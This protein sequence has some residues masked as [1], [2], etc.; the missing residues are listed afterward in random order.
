M[1][2]KDLLVEIGTEELPPRSLAK[3]ARAFAQSVFVGLADAGLKGGGHEHYAT[4]RRLAVLINDLPVRQ[5]DQVIERKGP[6]MV[7]AFGDNGEP[8][9]AALGFA[10]SCGVEVEDLIKV[11]TDKGA[12]LGFRSEQKGESAAHLLPD[13]VNQALMNL[14][15]AKRMR[16]GANEV[17]FVRPVHWVV[18][19]LGDKPVKAKVL[20]VDT[21]RETRG[22]RFHHPQALE[23]N[24]PR[25]YLA[26]LN[27]Q[28]KVIPELDARREVIRA[29]VDKA[30]TTLGGH[31]VIDPDLL[32]QVTALV[33]WPCALAAHFDQR[34]LEVPPEVL[35]STMQD[36]QRYF[37][38]VNDD[39][40]LQPHFITVANIES[41]D[42]DKVREGNERVIRPRFEDAAFFWTQDR[43]GRLADHIDAL[44]GVVFQ[45][46]LG[47]VFDKSERVSALATF[48]A[49]RLGVDQSL[50]R[51]AAVLSKCDLMTQM[52]GEFPALQGVMGR[53]YATHDGEPAAVAAAM[54]E[55]YLPRHA[56]DELPAGD[57]AQVLALADRLDT[58]VGIYAI[59]H[60]PTGARDPFGLRR[61]ALGVIRIAIE[62]KLDLDLEELLRGAAENFPTAVTADA[63]VPEVLAYIMDRLD[64]Y[65]AERDIGGDAVVAVLARKPT[66]LLDI[67]HRVRAVTHFRTLPDAVSLAS[68]NKRI[69]NILKKVDGALPDK[70]DSKLLVEDAEQALHANLQTL[71][72][73][74][75]KLFDEGA[76][77][78]G[79]T[80]LAELRAPVDKFFDDVLVMADDDALKHNR[81]ALLNQLNQ[82][83]SR[84]ADLSRLRS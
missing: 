19:L 54:E 64:G 66:H 1:A 4:P 60:K 76:Y 73:K 11:E 56:G 65:Y 84:A 79:L 37:P 16:W 32:D 41:A 57:V 59:G 58:L 45:H 55:Q 63:A 7:A 39:G 18:M 62:R 69:R 29:Q 38:V 83:C 23:I 42:P 52:V 48:I 13:I 8:T 36:H 71:S 78:Q 15:V 44:R 2:N 31:A 61:A 6:A 53:Y 75:E 77:E 50:A 34:F 68:A 35:V 12:W 26:V 40:A 67:D 3:L 28:G 25:D 74:V 30:A 49:G 24:K 70:V 27:Q 47:T 72:G 82:L 17:E 20:G 14:P 5:A 51:R 81:L 9:K 80:H 43:K 46:K 10:A 33:E 21:G 22:H